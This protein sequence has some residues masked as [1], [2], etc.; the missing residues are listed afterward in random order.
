MALMVAVM[1]VVGCTILV[2]LLQRRR[3]KSRVGDS[4]M[5]TLE[6]QQEDKQTEKKLLSP[7]SVR[8]NRLESEFGLTD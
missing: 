6:S 8:S 7:K 3:G 5:E 2:Y 4:E 1:T